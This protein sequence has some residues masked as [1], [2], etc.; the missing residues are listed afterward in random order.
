MKTLNPKNRAVVQMLA[1]AMLWSLGGIFIKLVPWS[2]IAI[3]GCRSAVAAVVFLIYMK[4]ARIP[5]I[6]NR[7]TALSGF[8]VCMTY[9]CFVI[10][11][12]MT[13]AANAI[14]LQF[15]APVFILI[16]SG[17]FLGKRFA[18]RDI[19]AVVFTMGGIALFF[20]DQLGPGYLLGNC[21]AILAGAFF[22]GMY[23]TVGEAKEAERMSAIFL[24]QVFAAA[25]GVP[26]A[27]L[28]GVVLTG[29]TVTYIVILG[30]LQLAVPYI[31]MAKAVE[32][33]PPLACALLG[34]LEPMLNPV[35]VMLFDGETPGAFAL[36][37]AVVVITTIT[38]WSVPPKRSQ[39]S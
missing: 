14:V 19:A 7:R 29:E 6:F 28:E 9:I 33:C 17:L 36:M 8:T 34:A 38:V 12:K 31:L 4:A 18:A 24:G 21:I 1:C 10:A 16:F 22:G 37:G 27:A 2:G 11:N 23:V 35:W 39:T 5:I 26:T 30:V 32:H 20:F 3:A 25:V 15:T 13:T